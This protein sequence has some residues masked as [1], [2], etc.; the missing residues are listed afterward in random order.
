MMR[1]RDQKVPSYSIT[2]SE[3][4]SDKERL[5]KLAHYD[6]LTALPNGIFFNEILNKA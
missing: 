2:E 4:K 1:W 5:T 6:L 3:I